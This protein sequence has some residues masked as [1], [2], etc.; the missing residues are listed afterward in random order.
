MKLGAR[1]IPM[2]AIAFFLVP[3]LFADDTTKPADLHK[4]DESVKST[5]TPGASDRPKKPGKTGLPVPA[6]S[7]QSREHGHATPKVEL[8]MGYSFWRAVPD[9]TRNRTDAMHGGSASLAYNLNNHLGLVFDFGGFRV[10][11]VEFTSPGAGFSP[12]RVVDVDG[13]VF[14]FLFGPRVSFR[15]HNRLTPF[16]QVLGGAARASEVTLNG[17]AAPIPACRPLSEETVFALTAGAG[18][19]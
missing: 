12:S 19:T 18:W 2:M 16:L 10:D 3:T 17:C 4:K 5:T 13:N 11:S 9:S 7:S 15:S 1:I 6:P 14:T 8:F